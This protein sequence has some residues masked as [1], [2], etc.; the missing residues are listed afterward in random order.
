GKL[1]GE[2]VGVINFGAAVSNFVVISGGEVVFCRDIPVGGANYTNEISKTLGVTTQEAESL[3]LSA[4]SRREVPDDVHAIIQTT[5]DMI[6]DEI[7]NSLDFLS[8][9]SASSNLSRIFY[10]GGSAGT[11]GLIETIQKSTGLG[12]ELF[13]PFQKIRFNSRR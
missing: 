13:N 5:N 2:T 8:A 9:T 6:A 4:V 10:T 11:T 3:K 7:R 12:A 1:R